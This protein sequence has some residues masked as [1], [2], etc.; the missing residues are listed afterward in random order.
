MK[1]DV[2]LWSPKDS[3][4]FEWLEHLKLVTFLISFPSLH[5]C[6]LFG[7]LLQI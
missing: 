3:S 7:G 4:G 1:S 2:T 5:A 6:Q